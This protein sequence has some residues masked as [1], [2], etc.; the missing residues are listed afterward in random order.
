[1]SAIRQ[2]VQALYSAWLWG[3]VP[4][5]EEARRYLLGRHTGGRGIAREVA[6]TSG[7]G[8]VPA[9]P[10]GGGAAHALAP[11]M[12]QQ[13]AT[14]RELREVSV[15]CAEAG[16]TGTQDFPP[17]GG[18]LVFPIR[19][20]TGD[21]LGFKY[22]AVPGIARADGLRY[23]G[24]SGGM[25]G[26]MF[27]W[28]RWT[29]ADRRVIAVEGEI[30]QLSIETVRLKV[31]GLPRPLAWYGKELT[32]ERLRFLD[33]RVAH[34]LLALDADGGGWDCGGGGVFGWRGGGGGGGGAPRNASLRSQTGPGGHPAS[35]AAPPEG[36]GPQRCAHAWLA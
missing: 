19:A 3:D 24:T 16:T 11:A 20:I 27:G 14:E 2:Q 1:M 22:R 23:T 13:G 17:G 18:Y 8:Y 7:I 28:E 34:V 10:D 35:G 30:D 15:V 26:A 25:G 29:D 33:G 4:G 31:P 6:L 32:D 5:A 36:A 12:A 21:I 9:A